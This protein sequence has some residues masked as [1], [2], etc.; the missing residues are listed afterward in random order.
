MKV[1]NKDLTEY[2]TAI[3]NLKK[4]LK[5]RGLTYAELAQAIGLSES[6][7]KKSLSAK[8]GSFQRLVQIC[9]FIGI[10]LSEVIDVHHLRHISF[11]SEQQ[12][13]FKKKFLL[14]EVYWM[15]VY[16][17]KEV[18]TIQSKLNI[19]RADIFK[20]IRKLDSLKLLK[21]LP[22]DR[23]K[24]PYIKAIRWVGEGEFIESLYRS[25]SKQFFDSISK[26]KGP[27]SEFFTIRYMPMTSNTF[28]EYKLAVL[29]LEEEFLRRSTLEMKTKSHDVKHVRWMAMM[30]NRSFVTGET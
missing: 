8:D 25:W 20:I 13:E 7:L 18:S 29:N 3:V 24:L 2:Q 5:L 28:E 16:E 26:P 23:I 10:T 27:S 22:A 11:N 4:I 1:K 9:R 19:N 12:K 15:L 14:F 30:D 6:G 21:L 17:R